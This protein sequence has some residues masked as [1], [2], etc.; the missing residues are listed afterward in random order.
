MNEL[1]EV[2]DSMLGNQTLVT[3]W[4]LFLEL[5]QG[6]LCFHIVR[7]DQERLFGDVQL[8]KLFYFLG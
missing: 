7:D 5:G 4:G 6:N 1:K 2:M 3:D 8:F